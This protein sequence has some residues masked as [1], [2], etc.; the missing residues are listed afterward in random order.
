MLH[1]VS[2]AGTSVTKLTKQRIA[3]NL[4]KTYSEGPSFHLMQ[5]TLLDEG[6]DKIPL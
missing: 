6:L 2:T 3:K 1:C 5:W 4:W